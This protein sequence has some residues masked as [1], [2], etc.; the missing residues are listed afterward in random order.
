MTDAPHQGVAAAVVIIAGALAP[1]VS[2]RVDGR[3]KRNA[4]IRRDVACVKACAY[5]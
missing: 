2:S 5:V 1:A 4:A 3:S